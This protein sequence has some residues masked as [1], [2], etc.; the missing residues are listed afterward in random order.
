MGYSPWGHK[1]LDTAERLSTHSTQVKY[2]RVPLP[3]AASLRLPG[4]PPSSPLPHPLLPSPFQPLP[5]TT[6]KL[7]DSVLV[8]GALNWAFPHVPAR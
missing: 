8:P 4:L 1:E 2:L 3:R 6:R 5:H 7:H